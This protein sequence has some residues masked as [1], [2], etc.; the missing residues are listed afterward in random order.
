MWTLKKHLD[1]N[2]GHCSLDIGE[3]A[4]PNCK[5]LETGVWIGTDCEN[6]KPTGASD[7]SELAAFNRRQREA[8]EA[9]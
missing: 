1:D 2:Y 9:E 6:W 5:C 7:W 3:K 4:S 8:Q